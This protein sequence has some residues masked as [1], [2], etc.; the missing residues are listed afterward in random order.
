MALPER[1][2]DDCRRFRSEIV[3]LLDGSGV[4]A[5]THG[6]ACP[7]CSRA[8]ATRAAL[9]RVLASVPPIAAPA[10]LDSAVAFAGDPAELVRLQLRK[11]PRRLAPPEL[12]ERVGRARPPRL[13]LLERRRAQWRVAIAAA[14]VAAV[15]TSLLAFGGS[16]RPPARDPLEGTA[17]VLEH[18]PISE[19]S[20][21]WRT[22][23]EAL[24]G[25]SAASSTPPGARRNF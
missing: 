8:V 7:S 25:A 6:A 5:S 23:V 14:A 9:R 13:V 18:R 2:P 10:S 21:Y 11:L 24:A 17:F 1:I 19:L 22:A 4:D 16:S 15:G 3:S 20:P 12:D